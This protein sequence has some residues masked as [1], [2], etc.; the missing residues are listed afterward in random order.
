MKELEV[1]VQRM[2]DAG[3]SEEAIASVVK[4]YNSPGKISDPA[5]VEATAGSKNNT[6]SVSEDGSLES[7]PK[8]S[9]WQSIK[10]SFSNLY[11]QITDIGE[12]YGDE[13]G[14]DAAKD[15]ATNAVFSALYGQKNLEN[16]DVWFGGDVGAENTL[17]ALARYEK[18][19]MEMK[20][21]KG[22]IESAK[23]GDIGGVLA[24]SINAVT[25]MIGSVA[26]GGATFGMGYMAD[27]TARN[28]MEYNKQ[29]AENLGISLDELIKSGEADNITPVALGAA[30]MAS[31]SLGTALTIGATVVTRG[32]AAKYAPAL[33]MLPKQLMNRVLY[34]SKARNGLLMFGSG[35]TEYGTEVTQHAID[36]INDELGRVA[37]TDEEAKIGETYWDAITS[38][39]GQ[40]AGLQGFIGGGGMVAGSYSAK[41]MTSVRDVVD[42]DALD[43]KIEKLSAERL[44]LN[45][46]TDQT[47][48]DGIEANIANIEM[49]ISDMVIKGN[50]IYNSLDNNQL[51]ELESFSDLSDATAFKIT[52]LNKKLRLNQITEGEYK[53]AKDGFMAEYNTAKQNL[54]DKKLEENIAN[55]EGIVQKETQAKDIETTVLETTQETEQ[56]MNKLE[57]VSKEKKQEF[58]NEKG[59]VAGFTVG[60]KIF[61]NK[62]VASKTGQI[63]VAKHE[64]LHKVMNAMVGGVAAQSKMVG[65]LRRAMTGQ[66]RKIVDQEMKNRGYTSKD[67]YATEYVNVFSDLIEQERVSFER[68]TM[69]KAG[70]AIKRFFQ[71]QGFDNI[72]FKDGRG[73]YNFLKDFS[74]NKG[75]S[76]EAK[77]ALGNVKLGKEGGLQFSKTLTKRAQQLLEKDDTGADLFSNNMLLDMIRST[78]MP[79]RPNDQEDR[80]GA[81]EALIERNWPVIS[82]AIKFDPNGNIPM[83]SVKEALAEQMLGIFPAVTLPNGK[84][85]SRKTPLL[86][87]YD[88]STEVT[89]FLSGTL[90]NRQAEIFTRAKAIGGVEQLGTDISEA[91]NVKAEETKKDTSKKARKL[92]SFDT[93]IKSIKVFLD[94]EGFIVDTK[95]IPFYSKKL[96]KE[97]ETKIK[98]TIKNAVKKGLN[99]EILINDL[100]KLIEKDIKEIIIKDLGKIT[101]K[102]G[103]VVIPQSYETIIRESF[104][105]I[106]KAYPL[107]RI[108]KLPF[109]K[110]EKIGFTDKKNLKEDNPLLK[111]DSYFRK[112]NFKIYKPSKMDFV[113][114]FLQGGLTTLLARQKQLAIDISGDLVQVELSKLLND[115][116]YLKSLVD[117]KDN[118]VVAVMQ[119]E[120]LITDIKTSLDPK[121]EEKMGGDVVQ[122]S[123]TAFAIDKSKRVKGK[124]FIKE[125]L[126]LL[127]QNKGLF[128][129]NYEDYKLKGR[130]N[131]IAKTV[132]D[133]LKA[134]LESLKITKEEAEQISNEV[135]K[136]FRI[137]NFEKKTKKYSKDEVTNFLLKNIKYSLTK[138]PE[139]SAI[140]AKMGVKNLK[141][142]NSR[143]S[144]NQARLGIKYL[145]DNL[146]FQDFFKYLYMST[147]GPARLGGF[148]I[149]KPI[150]SIT[151]LASNLIKHD[152]TNRD[153]MFRNKQDIETSLGFNSKDGIGRN[154]ETYKSTGKVTKSNKP[155]YTDPNSDYNGLSNEEQIKKVKGIYE[156]SKAERTFFSETL[157]P[158]LRKGYKNGDL[159]LEQIQW[160][161]SNFFGHQFSV[162]KVMA[163]TRFLPS[164]VDGNLLTIK[165]QQDLGFAYKKGE[166]RIGKKNKISDGDIMVLEHMIP[167]NYM[168]DLAYYYI[169]T[170]DRSQFDLELENYDTAIL[171]QKQDDMLKA[172]GTQSDMS[173][174]HVPGTPPLETRYDGVGMHFVD[175]T[176]G[177]VVGGGIQYSKTDF[178]NQNISNKAARAKNGPK[179]GISVFD[180]DDTLAKTKSMIIVTMPD[181]T[182]TKIDAT[183]FALKSADLEAA[184]ATFDFSEFNEVVD[185]KKGPLFE[186]A[187]KRQGKFGSKDIFILTARPQEAAYAIHAFL[188]GIGLEIPIENIT[189]LEDGRP[190]AKAE[191][192]RRKAS[193]G[194]NDFYFADDAYKNVEAVQKEL[195]GLGLEPNVEQ[196]LQFS[197]ADTS[198]LDFEFNKVLEESSGVGARTN[199]SRAAAKAKGSSIESNWFIP[200]GA[201]D[202]V[203]LI[204]QFL[205]KGIKG[206]KQL[207]FFDK[208]LFKPFNR[209]IQEM[210]RVKQAYVNGYQAIKE[211]YPNIKEKLLEK[212]VDDF[213]VEDAVRVYIWNKLGYE[214]PGMSKNDINKLVKVVEKNNELK[215]YA[216]SLT[217]LTADQNYVE[218]GVN[219]VAGSIVADID[220]LTQKTRRKPFLQE[221]IDNKNIIF[222][223]KNLNKIESIYGTEFREALEDMLWRMENGTNRRTGG[224]KLVN[225]FMDWVNNSVG[226][227]MFFNMRSAVL[228]TISAVNFI[229]W[230]DNNPAKAAEAL[231]NWDQYVADFVT[232][233]N[234]D[235]L[236][237]RRTGL[238]MD[239]NEQEIAA[240]IKGKGNT[241]RAL[242]KYLLTK[243]FLPTQMADSF[244][245]A[246]GGAAFYRNRINTYMGQGMSKA[247]AE[248][249]AFEDFAEI[250][251]RTQQSARPD[252]ISQQQAG[253]LG[254][255]ILA[256]QNT[257]MQ[258]T[259]LMK[260]AYLDLVNGRGNP[261]EHISK[262]AYYGFVQNLIFNAL[263]S[264]LFALAFEDDEDEKEKQLGKKGARIINNMADTVL[265]GTGV[266]GAAA[267]TVKN[268]I[269]KFREQD[270]KGFNADHTYT[271]IEFANLS[272]PVG[273][274]LRRLY[275]GIQTYKFNKDIIPEYG[276]ADPG[277]PIYQSIGNVTAAFTNVPLD[278]IVN[279]V[280]NVR[281]SL[282]RENAAWQRIANFLGWN[283]WDV[284]STYDPKLES[285]KSNK[286][287]GRK[288]S[289][290]NKSARDKAY[291][292]YRNRKK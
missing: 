155:W 176:T 88:G 114:Y 218:P 52:E 281:A 290:R 31:E 184:G 3:E 150:K 249:K 248:T 289:V 59:Q 198:G 192:I 276:Y 268:I 152:S 169:L 137:K 146:D 242:L 36:E 83:E 270:Q 275:S 256:F 61:I 223:E 239:I 267:A 255:L 47:V 232:I 62:E 37:G 181:Q 85:I 12:F 259:R 89:T 77:Q 81:V 60:N 21:T 56:E 285:M 46:A 236:K 86:E 147:M 115:T 234:S 96:Q 11:E 170:G 82:N 161:M 175:V 67:Q 113:K 23:D 149:K 203:G 134:N 284:G 166:K 72:S 131:Y 208:H 57:N 102:K 160:M 40:E 143:D 5:T 280:N 139:F 212:T 35:A 247:E 287:K 50:Q 51:S 245:I 48:R 32:R 128:V 278:R 101:S 159:N 200:P 122:F 222:S 141:D 171:P 190:Q 221:W 292:Q 20:Q 135:G 204:Y 228:Q 98:Q 27:F 64:F 258:Y 196:A 79:K 246:S 49:E 44:K 188:K 220:A 257:P 254:R 264:A 22:I 145:F 123:K 99:S 100:K 118:N 55:I 244:A 195:K 229:N 277:N 217:Q 182:V 129:R 125:F 7:P 91:K 172:A 63:N 111:K 279:K 71:G 210:N 262:I 94:N 17:D 177:E 288:R 174:D 144:L 206:T 271:V 253:P 28:Y 260:K 43:K 8:I 251:E 241:P 189:G 265:R 179:K 119:A 185:G 78:G 216:N 109:I 199:V 65:E 237:Q 269:L 2:I 252:L 215:S 58:K 151:L 105:Q 26:Y 136:A 235:M 225:R 173:L 104:E 180:F 42:G 14:K 116:E 214:I 282:N 165:Q 126:K 238:Q 261:E 168:R 205:G 120:K 186:L 87:T 112:D 148:D 193:E 164:D 80:F 132:R 153:S 19:Q 211:K 227:I 226:A 103:E 272:P 283:T 53:T 197:K 110:K 18:D 224:N 240:S 68:S 274:K 117:N 108:K 158:L 9:T 76:A 54:M 30:S 201:E 133:I 266:Y 33:R 127:K 191:W 74:K 10:N 45:T 250:S 1:I 124:S 38:L 207:E 84:K 29:K 41:A 73:V 209:A 13:G 140:N 233:F 69:D 142:L 231:S 178:N 157:L 93:M 16:K 213:Y 291:E 97:I 243:G 162:G 202:F 130:G 95:A 24:G 138:T 6:A 66:Q 219:W 121:I 107:A 286:K 273:S 25:N 39:E 183:E 194:Y 75:L 92:T 163:G 4:H 156:D 263:Q 70:D 167:A 154:S 15:I 230:S 106:L 187:M 90:K 34:N